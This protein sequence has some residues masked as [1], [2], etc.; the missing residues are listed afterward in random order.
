MSNDDLR[1]LVREDRI[2]RSVFLDPEIFD[3]EMKRIFG[4]VWV[5]VGHESQVP[6]AG[7]YYCTTIGRQPIVM[8]RHSDG[9][10]YV[11]HNRCAHRGA[12]VITERSGNAEYFHCMY[13][14]WTYRNDGSLAGCP[15]RSQEERDGFDFGRMR[16]E[17][18]AR[19]Q[20]YHGLVFASLT[21]EGPGLI[22]Y[23]GE[24]VRADIDEFVEAAPEGRLEVNA[25]CHRYEYRG[26]WK[27]QV[28]NMVDAYHTI[29]TH[30]SSTDSE[31]VQ[32][33][34]RSG[35]EAVGVTGFDPDDQSFVRDLLVWTYPRAHSKTTTMFSEAQAGGT[36]EDYRTILAAKHGAERADELLEQKLHNLTIYPSFDLLVVQSAIRVV[37]P[38]SMNRT[39]VQIWPVR[40][41]GIPEPV[42]REQIEYVN[43]THAA[44]SFVQ[45]DDIEAFRRV[46]DGLA[47]EGE[48]WCLATRGMKRER[49]GNQGARYGD[50][51]NDLGLRHQ[52]DVWLSLITGDADGRAGT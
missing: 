19:R 26:N 6:N 12:R 40:L 38:I 7:D 45:T 25:G 23:L 47:S 27:H 22:E 42:F 48:E 29:P 49:L 33:K 31:G 44:A 43:R 37:I 16:M 36:W 8:S 9:E 14:G 10:V 50:N 5:Y 41:K 35:D 24:D 17:P 21:Q 4:R 32:F 20:T 34:R 3:L 1:K 28:E 52:H 15:M 13:H 39:E 51:A 11:V 2:H 30:L 18:V 46:Q